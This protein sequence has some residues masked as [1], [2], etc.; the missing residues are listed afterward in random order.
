MT[1][2]YRGNPYGVYSSR[3]FN[4]T[5]L[6]IFSTTLLFAQRPI[7]SSFSPSSG[8]VGTTVTITGS[9]FSSTASQNVV[10]FGPV[11]AVVQSSTVNSLTAT[12]PAGAVSHSIT[13]TN[14]TTGLSAWSSKPFRVTFPGGDNYLSSTSFENEVVT[15]VQNSPRVVAIGDLDGDGKPDVA[16]IGDFGGSISYLSIIKNT[17]TP[18]HVSFAPSIDSDYSGFDGWDIRLADINGDG[19]LDVISS[20]SSKLSIY[21][22]ISTPGAIRFSLAWST[23]AVSAF[24]YS[25]EVGDMDNDG[26]TDLV[27]AATGAMAVTVMRNLSTLDSIKFADPETVLPPPSYPGDNLRIRLADFD[28]DGKADI[29]MVY[30]YVDSVVIAH[31]NSTP[32]NVSFDQVFKYSAGGGYR[33]FDLCVADLDGDDKLDIAYTNNEN[34]HISLLK[35]ITTPGN[36]NFDP[37]GSYA[38]VYYSGLIRDGDV[39]GDGKPDLAFTGNISGVV[40]N[41]SVLLNNSVPCNSILNSLMVMDGGNFLDMVFADMD[42]DGKP[43][44]VLAKNVQNQIAIRRNNISQQIRSCAGDTIVL[45]AAISGTNYQWQQSLGGGFTNI[46]DDVQFSGVNSAF[47]QIK[48][49]PASLDNTKYRCIA[50]GD[51][52]SVLSFFVNTSVTPSISIGDCPS[53]QCSGDPA[54][55]IYATTQNA[56]SYPVYQWQD[57]TNAQG[58]KNIQGVTDSLH[59]QAMVDSSRIRCLLI[60]SSRC[61]AVDSVFSN[62]I[63]VRILPSIA[64]VNSIAGNTVVNVGQST[65]LTATATNGGFWPQYQWQDSTGVA[66]WT[67]IQGANS[68]NVVYTPGKSGDKVRC[69]L[70]STDACA[71][72]KTVYS[73]SL[74]FVVSV[75]TAVNP[76]P[77]NSYS[78]HLFPNPSKGMLNIDGL[79]LS[80]NWQTLE[81]LSLSGQRQVAISLSGLT[82]KTVDV[83]SFPAGLYLAVLKRKNSQPVY[84]KFV[85]LAK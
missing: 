61:A 76:L 26:R 85:K 53:Q 81:I 41:I 21:K 10:Y 67:N 73:N 1:R 50:D 47:L 52:S 13:V 27:F 75:V 84:Y 32:G 4:C 28:G 57:S 5:L 65:T 22:N 18:G 49:I 7:I 37:Y 70:R 68:T 42:G 30:T 40:G 63:I 51:T 36:L 8:P 33:P 29:A 43:D 16:T 66:G 78:I 6:L 74:V 79:R 71:L 34:N 35:N 54:T 80:D 2:P 48:N 82:E 62:T 45:P 25:M 11:K 59:Y 39:N 44:L 72:P 20:S 24:A 77:V 56:G 69:I 9:N 17:S 83:S 12:I 3:Y 58:W 55:A 31:N 14:T 15:T 23:S 60:S 19:L 46:T 64:P 38:F